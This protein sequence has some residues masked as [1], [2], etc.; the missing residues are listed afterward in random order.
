MDDTSQIPSRCN[1]KSVAATVHESHECLPCDECLF[2]DM[3]VMTSSSLR[4]QHSPEH[5]MHFCFSS[6]PLMRLKS[7]NDH[8]MR[9][10]LLSSNED[11]PAG[12]MGTEGLSFS[13]GGCW[14]VALQWRPVPA[15]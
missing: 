11:L 9:R 10:G 5:M 7:R 3:T 6:R 14:G 2:V 8:V 4:Q 13:D 1:L 15:R 12:R